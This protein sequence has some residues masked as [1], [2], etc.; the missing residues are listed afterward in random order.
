MRKPPPEYRK[1]TQT[2]VLALKYIRSG[3]TSAGNQS[4][5]ASLGKYHEV[6]S[7]EL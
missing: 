6:D 7:G 2:N 4:K 1:T 3:D 5:Q